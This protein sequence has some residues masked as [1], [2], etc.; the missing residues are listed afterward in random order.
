MTVIE[1]TAP[2]FAKLESLPEPLAFEIV[3]RVDLLVNFPEIGSPL[4]SRFRALR[5]CRQLIIN[6]WYR[7]IYE[8]DSDA[9]TVYI[10]A[11]QNCRQKLPTA[12]QLRSARR[13]TQ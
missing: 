12:G 7:V 10:L 8:Y 6:R 13:Q 5:N 3:E 1:W 4:Q 11:V 2:A 9:E